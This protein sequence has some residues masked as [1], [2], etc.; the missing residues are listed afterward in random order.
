MTTWS[1]DLLAFWHFL[2]FNQEKLPFVQL[3]SLDNTAPVGTMGMSNP[4]YDSPESL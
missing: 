4:N 1:K 2:R 3:I